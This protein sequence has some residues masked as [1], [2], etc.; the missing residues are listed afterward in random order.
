MDY[1]S[2]IFIALKSIAMDHLIPIGFTLTK[3][4]PPEGF[5]SRYVEFQS[6]SQVFRVVWDGRDSLF[7]VTFCNDIQIYPFPRWKYIVELP[8]DVHQ[9]NV[10]E[11][12]VIT[13]IEEPFVRFLSEFQ[14]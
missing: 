8:F 9:P 7:E 4:Q 1:V 6:N 2:S 10:N 5:G 14:K 12:A 11:K 3:D 13:K